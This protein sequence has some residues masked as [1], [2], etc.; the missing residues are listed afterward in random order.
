MSGELVTQYRY[1]VD[2]SACLEM[3]LDLFWRR[4]VINLHSETDESSTGI[5]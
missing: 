5:H 4:L 3:L 2:R 1:S